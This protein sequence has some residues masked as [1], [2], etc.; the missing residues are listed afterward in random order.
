MI[1]PYEC[2]TS[3]HAGLCHTRTCVKCTMHAAQILHQHTPDSLRPDSVEQ[4]E[5]S[6]YLKNFSEM[7]RTL[8]SASPGVRHTRATTSQVSLALRYCT[9]S[10]SGLEQCSLE[11]RTDAL[12]SGCK[13]DVWTSD[14]RP[15][16]ASSCLCPDFLVLLAC[17]SAMHTV[18]SACDNTADSADWSPRSAV[19]WPAMG[20]WRV[21]LLSASVRS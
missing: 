11:C 15:S 19:S 5:Q 13:A 10:A 14:L 20:S 3:A 8:N 16:M 2:C 9:S 17:M 6:C 21:Q 12:S 7:P 4:V 1:S 18:V